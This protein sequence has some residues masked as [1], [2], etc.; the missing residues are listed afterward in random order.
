MDNLLRSDKKSS[1]KIVTEIQY[2]G[3]I[4]TGENAENVL[5]K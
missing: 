3:K 4:L 5:L 2:K 1:S